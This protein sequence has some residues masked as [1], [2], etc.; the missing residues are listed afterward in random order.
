[1][2]CAKH[3]VDASWSISGVTFSSTL[4]V[5]PLSTYDLIVG[6][7]WLESHSPMLIH[8]SQKWLSI[9]LQDTTVTLHGVKSSVLQTAVIQVCS[10]QGLSDKEQTMVADLPTD[11][12]ELLSRFSS[13]FD[14]PN[15]MPPVK[16]PDQCKCDPIDMLLH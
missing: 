13:V 3:I 6:M 14:I 4:R 7:D 15:T 1:M 9:P 10:L 16:V 12:Q 5:L 8:W 2:S 11:I